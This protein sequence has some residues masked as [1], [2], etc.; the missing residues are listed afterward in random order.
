M[1]HSEKMEEDIDTKVV[2]KGQ[3]EVGSERPI[4]SSYF[5][6]SEGTS[7]P[8]SSNVKGSPERLGILPLLLVGASWG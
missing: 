5:S 8:F 3:L 2:M 6:G 4:S 7:C 1:A